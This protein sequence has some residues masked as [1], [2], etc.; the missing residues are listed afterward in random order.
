[1]KDLVKLYKNELY[2]NRHHFIFIILI[3]SVLS[4]GVIWIFDMPD[5]LKLNIQRLL[6]M[7]LAFFIH[8]LLL[9]IYYRSDWS[10]QTN[11]QLL[12]LPVTRFTIVL[13]KF[14]AI[15]RMCIVIFLVSLFFSSMT[16]RYTPFKSPSPMDIMLY[17]LGFFII[18]FVFI[19]IVCFV[20]AI[21]YTVQRFRGVLCGVFVILCASFF[22][23]FGKVTGFIVM[24]WPDATVYS[25]ILGLLFIS[26]GLLLFQKYG[27]V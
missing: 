19:S 26:I 25:L 20:E 7:S 2:R 24:L 5:V 3:Y 22:F 12:T 4:T 6:L 15:L 11:Y 13:S 9:A 8:P 17:P 14:L 1:M 23:Y 16:I 27:E 21:R 18:T 10:R